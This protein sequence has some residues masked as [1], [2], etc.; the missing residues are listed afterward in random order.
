MD[1]D[2][3]NSASDIPDEFKTALAKLYE[4]LHG[5]GVTRS[6]FLEG[7]KQGGYS[8]GPRTLDR[9]VHDA[10]T[11][12]TAILEVK[13][14]GG[15]HCLEREKRNVTSGWV[16]HENENGSVVS[17]Q[18]FFDF[19]KTYFDVELSNGTI[20][21]YLTED[22]FSSRLI[23]RKGI[24]FMVDVEALCDMYWN[25]VI[26][27]N[28]R[29]RR[30]KPDKFASI[31]FTFTGH[32]T[33]RGSGYAPKG[34]PQPMVADSISR[35]TNC[36][37]TVEWA[38]GINRTPP[39]LFTYN[40]AFRS[41]RNM[42]KR[43]KE[44]FEHLHECLDKYGISQDRIKYVGNDTNETRTYVKECPELIRMFFEQ[45]EV[46][47]DVTIY[48]DEGNSFFEG[49]ASVL[50]AIGFKHICYPPLVHQYIS[51]NDNPLHGSSKQKWRNCGVDYKDDVNSCL[52]L[53]SFLD[54]DI[55]EYSKYWWERNMISITE[56][57]VRELIGQRPGRLS[58][59]H[60]S[61]K[62]SY[63]EFMNQFQEDDE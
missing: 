26:I 58:H 34:G 6:L 61:W 19:A 5:K 59:L 13:K 52:A 46:P 56:E 51:V 28:F 50:K 39:M 31:D 16:L 23:K 38:D 63:E 42:T 18:S 32:R 11:R 62:R 36:I 41:D 8:V 12:G 27:Q 45:Y 14:S 40:S 22:G 48:S 33:E 54:K 10:N 55:T 37:I 29:A 25:W 7:L 57:G 4:F 53:L 17:L 47:P 44:Q 21:N 24:S 20:S 1:P 49:D 15:K 2:L 30:I 35:Y 43:R 60:K 3:E 9:W